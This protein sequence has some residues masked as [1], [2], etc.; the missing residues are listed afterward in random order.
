MFKDASRALRC[1]NPH[2]PQ[3]VDKFSFGYVPR[4][5]GRI[6]HPCL[7]KRAKL[8]ALR[9]LNPI[10]HSAFDVHNFFHDTQAIFLSFSF[11]P[12]QKLPIK[13]FRSLHNES[14]SLNTLIVYVGVAC[15]TA[16]IRT[17]RPALDNS[18]LFYP[19]IFLP[20]WSL[21]RLKAFFF[22]LPTSAGSPRYF[23]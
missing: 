4:N 6:L 15:A 21:I 13:E 10:P 17:S 5:S 12:H 19:V 3:T 16:L 18:L 8:K 20:T 2:G 22:P 11:C 23:S 14:G 7:A 1:L 9:S